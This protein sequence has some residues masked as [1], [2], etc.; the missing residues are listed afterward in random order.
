LLQLLVSWNKN[1]TSL[2]FE[3]VPWVSILL[4]KKLQNYGGN[5]WGCVSEDAL[6]PT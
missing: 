5:C 6:A 1:K 3:F 2:Q 4:E